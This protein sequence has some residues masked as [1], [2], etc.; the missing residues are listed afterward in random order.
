MSKIIKYKIYLLY[1]ALITYLTFNT[2][3]VSDE[4]ALI[5][6]FNQI[7]FTEILFPESDFLPASVSQPIKHYTHFISYHFI[8]IDQFVLLK[9]LKTFYNVL[10]LFLISKF[11]GLFLKK[12]IA[13]FSSFLIVFF[14]SHDSTTYC[15]LGQ[16]YVLSIA[17]YLFSYYLAHRNKLI[18]A[19]IAGL[20]ASFISY[21]SPPIALAMFVLFLLDKKFKKGVFIILPNAI[22][23]TYYVAITEYFNL[24]VSR[25]I[26]DVNTY[27]FFK[28]FILQIATFLDAMVGPSMWLK[29][30]Y[31]FY[32]LQMLSIIIGILIT[33]IFYKIYHGEKEKYNRNLIISLTVF[34]FASFAMFAKTGLYPQI[35]FN[36]G[37]RT[38][39]FGSLLIV[40]LITAAPLSKIAKT[41]VFAI[42]IFMVLGISDHWKNWEQQQQVVISNIK[43]N[44]ALKNYSDARIIYVSGNQYSKYGPI[45]HIE[46][47]SE[48]WVPRDVFNL[49]LK[50]NIRAVTIN[51]RHV[52]EDGY[53]VD[54]KY[55][56]KSEIADYINIYD[57]GNNKLFKLDVENINSYI[58]SLPPENRH[59]IMLSDNRS[60]S[61]VKNIVI[62]LMP[63]LKY[64][65]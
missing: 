63:R 9:I 58:D 22:F 20:I 50:K 52:Y 61:F 39:V 5:K 35:N 57:S 16:G 24:G 55:N 28:R 44:Q 62:K 4:F 11:F 51:K 42:M 2:G 40:Y 41:V 48:S 25:T 3:I 31:S 56:S 27:V 59:W 21:S 33:V 6:V 18:T 43:N 64:A 26:E 49:A 7:D 37:N 12:N 13:L 32:Q 54:T 38:T 14:P 15:F 19:F 1:F 29:I 17:L 47:L 8:E 46:F 60:V 23:S 53:L 30:Y 65:L 36:L 45:S 10:A 34:A